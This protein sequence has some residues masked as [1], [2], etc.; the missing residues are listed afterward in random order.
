MDAASLAGK[1][2]PSVRRMVLRFAGKGRSIE[3]VQSCPSP[4]RDPF[5]TCGA[6]LRSRKMA[7]FA[8][9]RLEAAR[10][11]WVIGCRRVSLGLQDAFLRK[12]T[13]LCLALFW[14]GPGFSSIRILFFH[15]VLGT[16]FLNPAASLQLVSQFGHRL[17]HLQGE[18]PHLVRSTRST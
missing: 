15:S 12:I 16:C 14:G 3:S 18:T 2:G 7:P 17:G 6:D 13:M 9:W 5:A 10:S 11:C 4:V 8:S 1:F